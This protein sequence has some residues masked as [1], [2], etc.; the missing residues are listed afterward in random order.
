MALKLFLGGMVR[1]TPAGECLV[2][3]LLDPWLT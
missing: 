2:P 3:F 1:R